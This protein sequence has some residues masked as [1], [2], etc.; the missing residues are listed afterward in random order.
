MSGK[1]KADRP[2]VLDKT[3]PG[4]GNAEE[5]VLSVTHNWEMADTNNCETPFSTHWTE[6]NQTTRAI[7]LSQG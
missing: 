3:V 5:R 2:R 1:E 4:R 7:E 6:R